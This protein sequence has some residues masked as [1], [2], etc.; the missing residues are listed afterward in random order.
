[1][2]HSQVHTNACKMSA[3]QSPESRVSLNFYARFYPHFLARKVVSE[4]K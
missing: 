1:M 4:K 3:V 2:S